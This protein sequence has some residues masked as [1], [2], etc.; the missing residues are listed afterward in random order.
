VIPFPYLKLIIYTAISAVVVAALWA[1]YSAIYSAG[2]ESVQVEWNKETA[3]RKQAD[4]AQEVKNLARER[5]WN[6][7]LQVAQDMLGEATKSTQT[8]LDR[9]V[10]NVRADNLRLRER[11]RA[12]SN[13]L[14]TNSDPARGDDAAN[15]GG[16]SRADEELA[17]RIGAEADQVVHQLAACQQYVR[18]IAP[19]LK[20]KES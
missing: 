14:S 7:E 9:T 10:A 11:F 19:I 5:E 20:R 4:M 2:Q 18:S 15:K 17:L 6:R 8:E 3:Q 1:G 13:K 16:L 12:C